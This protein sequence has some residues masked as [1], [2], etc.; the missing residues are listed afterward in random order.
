M[1]KIL[2]GTVALILAVLLELLAGD[3]A[4]V[5]PLS[6]CVLHRVTGGMSPAGVFI[7]GFCTGLL[8]DLLY[9]RAF[10]G[11]ALIYAL[12]LVAVR[13]ICDRA[14]VKNRFAAALA[15][16]FLAGAFTIVPLCVLHTVQTGVR[17]LS[18][19]A[20]IAGIAG[21]AVFQLLISPG[22]GTGPKE[23]PVKLKPAPRPKRPPVRR[24]TPR[25]KETPSS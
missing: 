13:L 16:G 15:A 4:L 17:T 19:P 22:S 12:A 20:I 9:W 25:K 6:A 1:L 3:M 18:V 10:P 7:S 24:S 2:H 8:F 21:A 14:G 23:P 11:T 5:L